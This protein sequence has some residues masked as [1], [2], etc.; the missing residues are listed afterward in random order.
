MQDLFKQLVWD[1]LVKAA[2]QRLF[3]LVPF[4]G[5]GPIGTIITWLVLKY[6]DQL[7]DAVALY[8]NV[9]LISYRNIEF[10][11]TYAAAEMN[12]KQIAADKGIDSQEFQD[13][14]TVEKQALSN[15]VKFDPARMPRRS[16]RLLRNY[17]QR[18]SSVRRS[19]SDGGRR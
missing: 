14:R 15:V 10:G 1:T 7:Y 5:W 3:L 6:A 13:A 4:L 17:D 11:Q 12:L 8:I 19:G 16:L 9:E 2:L 18:H